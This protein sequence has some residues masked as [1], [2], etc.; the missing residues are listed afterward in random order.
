M[1]NVNDILSFKE[2]LALMDK[3]EPFSIQ[4]VTYDQRRPENTGEIRQYDEAL[5]LVHAGKLYGSER[6]QTRMES[7]STTQ[8]TP[9]KP[10]TTDFFIRDI[11]PLT[12]GIPVGHPVRVHP[13][14]IL[15]FNQ[16]K[17]MP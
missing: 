16:K 8:G 5:L 14:L 12:G 1:M 13:R 3:A 10:N 6:G 4:F 9:R 15:F 11:Q 7:V 2:V 17:V